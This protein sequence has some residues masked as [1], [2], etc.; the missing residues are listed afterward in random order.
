MGGVGT[1]ARTGSGW[2]GVSRCQCAL[3]E[4]VSL[5]PDDQIFLS[6]TSFQNHR[7]RIERA[8]PAGSTLVQVL[9][10][11]LARRACHVR[12]QPAGTAPLRAF[13]S[14]LSPRPSPCTV[15]VLVPGPD[16]APPSLRVRKLR[17]RLGVR[18]L[19]KESVKRLGSADPHEGRSRSQH[20]EEKTAPIL[21]L[22]FS[23]RR[24]LEPPLSCPFRAVP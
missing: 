18:W 16:W 13:A 1:R 3:T 17:D 2:R 12:C 15:L 6:Q 7:A 20:R 11:H 22:S 14:C 10:P 23:P 19:P 21:S 8:G 9:G 5:Q 24:K 4:T